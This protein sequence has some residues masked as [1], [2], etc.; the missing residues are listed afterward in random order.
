M[1]IVSSIRIMEISKTIDDVRNFWETNPLFAGESS[2]PVGSNE[3]FEEHRQV[4]IT[5]CFAG[6]LESRLFP[7]GENNTAVLDLGCG[8]GFW[9][10][11]LLKNGARRVTAV[12]ITERA[13]QL[14]SQRA[15]VYGLNSVETSRQNAECLTFP[16]GLFSHVNCLGVIHHTPSPASCIKE[17][18]RVLKPDGTAVIAVYYKNVYLKFWPLLRFIGKILNF[19][20][21]GLRGQGRESL[22]LVSDI[23][24]LI[25]IYD[26][27]DNPIG[28]AFSKREFTD[29]LSP[30]FKIEGCFYHFFPARSLPFR[31]PKWL[32][33]FLDAHTGFMIYARC[34][35]E[36]TA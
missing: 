31:V 21:G 19:I 12:D 20:G 32:H 10:I 7:S 28:K 24:E 2:Y 22:F 34:K 11:E 5:D 16:D 9:V 1:L 13:L 25:R 33:R 15:A 18:A 27:A 23:N 26:G 17:M 8:P 36:V 35:K 6:N 3:Y 30:Y 4:V 29:M 14:T